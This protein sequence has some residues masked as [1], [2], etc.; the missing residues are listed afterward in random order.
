MTFSF[1]RYNEQIYLLKIESP[2]TYPLVSYI[3]LTEKMRTALIKK[4]QKPEV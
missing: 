3:F 1:T 4:L 2:G